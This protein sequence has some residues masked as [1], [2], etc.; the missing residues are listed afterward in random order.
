M[1]PAG[2]YL[3]RCASRVLACV[4][5]QASSG[6]PI[7]FLG[8]SERVTTSGGS[9]PDKIGKITTVQTL[10]AASSKAVMSLTPNNRKGGAVD[11]TVLAEDAG[12]EWQ[13]AVVADDSQ[14]LVVGDEDAVYFFT[15]EVRC[16]RECVCWF[17]ARYSWNWVHVSQERGVCYGI[18]GRKRM[19]GWFRSYLVVAA[20]DTVSVGNPA[21]YLYDLKNKIVTFTLNKA[22]LTRVARSGTDRLRSDGPRLSPPRHLVSEFGA[23]F[24][25]LADHQVFMV[26]ELDTATKLE[27]LLKRDAFDVA[28]SV[29]YSSNFD[30]ASIVEIYL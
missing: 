12:C 11:T 15:A 22:L 25:V 17:R 10:F 20:L 14:S 21:V 9:R 8:F 23:L 28:I 29:A 26:T 16:K 1:A 30:R 27:G 18:E 7:T 2:F 3:T 6:T 4:T 13:C 24:V 5:P 19:L